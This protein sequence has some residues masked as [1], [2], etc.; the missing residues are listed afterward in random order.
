MTQPWRPGDP[1][2]GTRPP[3]F[4][5]ITPVPGGPG[6]PLPSPGGSSS[7]SPQAALPNGIMAIEFSIVNIA[8]NLT[9]SQMYRILGGSG[10]A[11]ATQIG[12]AAP[13]KGSIVGLT[14]ISTAAKSGGSF[15]AT[16]YRN[17]VASSATLT[18]GST[19]SLTRTFQPGTVPFAA[20]DVLDVRATTNGSYTPTTAD[21]EINL[22][23]AQAIN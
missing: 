4:V 17:G 6:G 8:A 16:A 14:I 18:W 3:P 5:G 15:V 12:F 10:G 1:G 7:S 21:I 23:L 9:A 13:F 11:Q 22:L 19:T 2:G 20:G